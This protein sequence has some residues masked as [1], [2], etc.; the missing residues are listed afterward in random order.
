[1]SFDLS[2]EMHKFRLNFF[3]NDIRQ[4][5]YIPILFKKKLPFDFSLQHAITSENRKVH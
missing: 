3:Y 4:S 5:E 2:H 1:M